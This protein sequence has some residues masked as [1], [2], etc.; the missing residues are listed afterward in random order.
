MRISTQHIQDLNAK[1]LVSGIAR[2]KGAAR[3]IDMALFRQALPVTAVPVES[4][5]CIRCEW[6]TMLRDG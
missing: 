6:Y 5:C 2:L 1:D 4:G 3:N